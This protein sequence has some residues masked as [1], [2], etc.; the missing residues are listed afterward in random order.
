MVVY[1]EASTV[2]TIR[3]TDC[4]SAMSSTDDAYR[5]EQVT[6]FECIK[7]PG[8]MTGWSQLQFMKF[9]GDDRLEHDDCGIIGVSRMIFLQVVDTFVAQMLSLL[10]GELRVKV[11]QTSFSLHSAPFTA[12]KHVTL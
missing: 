12:Y 4:V 11:T 3:V 9:I 1:G 7:L 5:M 6:S 10:D 8:H 2:S